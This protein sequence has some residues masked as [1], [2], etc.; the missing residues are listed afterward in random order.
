MKLRFAVLATICVAV[1]LSACGDPISLRATLPT[2]VD[3]LSVFALS[4]T[5]PAY[6]SALSI[7]GR[8]TV[9]ATGFGGFDVAFDIDESNRVVLYPA[10]LI[11]RLGGS[12]PSVGLQKVAGTFE[13]VESAPTTGY[14]VDSALVVSE[15]EVV[16]VEAAHNLGGDVCTFA[17]SPNLY[18]KISIDTVF[19]AT[20]TIKFRLGANPNCGFRSF[21]DGIPTS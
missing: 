9:P 3:T 12:L 16:V 21:A 6:P 10:K 20:R 8:Q 2:S 19:T 14:K 13:S 11:V 18:A 1:G 15:G 5:P 4:G 7:A 17:L